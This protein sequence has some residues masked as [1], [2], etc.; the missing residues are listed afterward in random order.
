MASGNPF[1]DVHNKL[2]GLLEDENTATDLIAARKHFTDLVKDSPRTRIKLTDV[3][4]SDVLPEVSSFADTPAVMIWHAR[5]I[6]KDRPASNA[7]MIV[8]QWE[9]LV[10]TAEQ[11][12]DMLFDLEWA[13]VRLLAN[14]DSLK[15]S[16]TWNGAYPVKKMEVLGV[17]ASVVDDSKNKNLRGWTSTWV[18]RT[19][20]WFSHAALIA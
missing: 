13:I 15:T 3:T 5:V 9:V 10:R 11:S 1:W 16:V 19:H 6:P 14:W 4:R 18:G 20:L 17:D 12:F 2:W 8:L 7:N